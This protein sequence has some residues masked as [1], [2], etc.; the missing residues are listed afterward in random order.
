MGS[1]GGGGTTNST[2]A[3]SIAPELQPLFAQTG[4]TV[5]NLQCGMPD[6]SQFFAPNVQNIPGFTQGQLD[7]NAAL[8]VISCTSV[9]DINKDSV[10]NVIDVQRVVNAVLGGACVSP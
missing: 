3:A 5:A 6:F 9:Y 1:S 8:G 7:V 2:S 4:T 10:C